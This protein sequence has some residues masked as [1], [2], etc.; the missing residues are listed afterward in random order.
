MAITF[1][2]IYKDRVIDN[3]Q[4]II[5]TSVPAIPLLYD[6]HRGQ[7][8][9]LIVPGVDT[10]VDFNSNAHIR[11][12]STIISYQLQRGTVFNKQS[13]I[14]RLTS[15]AEILKRLLYDNNNYEVSNINQWYG[16]NVSSV[17]YERDEDNPEIA[18]AI[19]TF[20]C[21]VNEVIS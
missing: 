8:S 9:I 11:Q 2:N 3:L 20:E 13:H 5:K 4:K 15:I 19:L 10:F 18:R 14:D 17:E 1:E 7:E 16:G 6:E 12:Y 21:N